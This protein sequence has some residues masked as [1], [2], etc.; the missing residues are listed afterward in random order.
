MASSRALASLVLLLGF[1][2]VATDA[3]SPSGLSFEERVAAQ[4]AIEEVYWRHRIWPAA[5]PTPKP[6]LPAVLPDETIRSKV[7]DYL[8]KSD[9][10]ALWWQRP[11]TAR[12]L[13]AELDRMARDTQDPE[14]LLELHAAL[15]NDAHLIAETLAPALSR[16]W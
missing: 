10:L 15:G 9:A 3:A 12:Q 13:Q 4:R 16:R 11:V 7:E 8:K 6:P 1:S 2:N 14:T 5:N